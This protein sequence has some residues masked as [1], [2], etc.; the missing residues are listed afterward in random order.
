MSE[1]K[2][3]KI[4]PRSGT[5]IT[6]GDSG[7][8]FTIP[9]GATLAIAG[10]VTGFTSA[11]IDDN[12]T[13]VAIT[14]DSS[15]RV[16]IGNTS[17]TGALDVKSGT[18]P[19][20]KVATAS[21]TASYNAG[22]L[23]TASNSATAGSRS[24]V[25]SL[26]ADGGDGSGT[27]NLTITKT[28]NGGNA[29]ITNQNNASLVFGTNNA[30]AARFTTNTFMVG[31]TSASGA[32]NG[33]ELKTNDE[34]RFTQ[35]A[36]TVIA[37]NRLSSDGHIVQFKKDNTSIGSI[38]ATGGDLEITAI[39][40]NHGGVRL[41]NLSVLPMYNGS[42]NDGDTK[43]GSSA[44]RWKELYLAGGVFLGGTGTANEL[45]DY[46]EG[47]FSPT[48][49]SS[50]ASFSYSF[51]Y[52][53]YTKIGRSVTCNIW[54]RGQS[55]GTTSNALKVANLPFTSISATGYFASTS[56]GQ[57]YLVDY[58]SNAKE[59]LGHV[60]SN[61]T[62]IDLQYSTDDAGAVN[63]PASAVDGSTASGFMITLTYITA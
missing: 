35:T 28:G 32:T 43:L 10:T 62:I 45:S 31:K 21:P 47:T 19:Q 4:S 8:T 34:S 16:G 11:G 24:V 42:L 22:F 14:I 15:E 5:A 44:N 20:L 51:Q 9:S 27:D 2:V 12:A 63:L 7:D 26:D 1:V 29:T 52:G 6:L 57:I 55:S 41:A 38:K 13:S 37:I 39:A 3:N 23:V 17:P 60:G 48:F 40:S 61:A 46:E 58:P 36:R 33:V 59:I 30:E 54:I 53:F 50:S 18:Q 56:F 25:L 49:T